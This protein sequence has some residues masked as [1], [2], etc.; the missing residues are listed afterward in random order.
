M[1]FEA[2]PLALENPALWQRIERHPIAGA[3]SLAFIRRLARENAWSQEFAVLAIQEYKRYC[4]LQCSSN[5]ARCPSRA[6]DQVWHLHLLYTRDYW[7]QFC[8]NVLQRDLHHAPSQ[9]AAKDLNMDRE[10]YALTLADYEREFG[11]APTSIWPDL[12]HRFNTHEHWQWLSTSKLQLS[13]HRGLPVFNAKARFTAFA[14]SIANGQKYWLRIKAAFATRLIFLAFIPLYAYAYVGPLEY[15]GIDFLSLYLKLLLGAGV[16]GFI[17]LRLLNSNVTPVGELTPDEIAMLSGGSARVLDALEVRLLASEHLQYS[18]ISHELTPGN[19]ARAVGKHLLAQQLCKVRNQRDRHAQRALEAQVV[20]PI[21][22]KLERQGLLLSPSTRFQIGLFSCMPLLALMIFGALKVMVG[23]SRGKPVSFLVIVLV[24][25]AIICLV[26]YRKR[27]FVSAGV[28]PWLK[29]HRRKLSRLSASPTKNEWP[30]A[31]AL[32]G[33]GALT[34]TALAS[35]ASWRQ[36]PSSS[37]DSS[38]YNNS[39]NSDSGGSDS[40][41]DSGGGCGGCGGGGGD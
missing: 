27:P 16:F 22:Q 8:P 38:S 26:T 19:D 34:G 24:L 28:H 20:K 29:A 12:N 25:T 1:N 7:R 18:P 10:N 6:V 2:V 5:G 4:Y 32:F 31:V 37:G 33:M 41:G 30:N 14:R 13:K 23:L 3:D 11:A 36:P 35:Y 15:S 39:S 21:A 17:L 9:G 40:G